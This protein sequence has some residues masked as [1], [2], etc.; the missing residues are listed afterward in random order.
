MNKCDRAC[1]FC[2]RRWT[3]HTPSTGQEYLIAPGGSV[4]RAAVAC[5]TKARNYRQISTG[6]IYFL[7]PG[8]PLR[9]RSRTAVV[10]LALNLSC[11]YRA[12]FGANY[13]QTERIYFEAVQCEVGLLGARLPVDNP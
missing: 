5:F 6:N 4:L 11:I 10:F 2:S 13:L 12:P 1:T 8:V 7:D 9:Q 3:L